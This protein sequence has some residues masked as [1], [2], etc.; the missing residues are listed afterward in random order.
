MK[1]GANPA[2]LQPAINRLS[3]LIA[4]GDGDVESLRATSN[5]VFALSAGQEL[6]KLSQVTS[7]SAIVLRGWL[8]RVRQGRQGK[9]QIL[10]IYVPGDIITPTPRVDPYVAGAIVALQDVALCLTPASPGDTLRDAFQI[11]RQMD[12]GRLLR[13][14]YRL[15]RMTASE[16]MYDWMIEIRDRLRI[17]GLAADNEFKLPVTQ[18]LVADILGLTAVHTNRTLK[19]LRL[20]GKLTWRMGKV[21]IAAE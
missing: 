13:Q 17:A 5:Q 15:G 19:D 9:R 6:I 1:Q 8:A 11:C 16:R 18:D 21:R 2:D 4:L 3:A 7:R 12:E 10:D 14:I 20:S